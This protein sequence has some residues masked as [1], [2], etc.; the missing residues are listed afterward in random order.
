MRTTSTGT[1]VS[2][3]NTDIECLRAFAVIGVV[4]THAQ[5]DLFRPG[6]PWLERVFA[7]VEPWCGVD[8]FFAIS[9]FV[10]ARSLLPQLSAVSGNLSAQCHVVATFWIRRAWRLLPS[11][12]LWLALILLASIIANRSGVFGSVG[13]NLM[14]TLAGLFNVA[15]LRF[16]DTMFRSP[17]GASF[18][19]WSLSLE[20]QFYIALPLLAIGTRRYFPWVLAAL[21][22]MQL[23]MQRSVL[24]MA[25]RTDALSLGVLLAM[26]SSTRLYARIEPRI[27][28]RIR[29]SGGFVL[30]LL[31]S[32]M[33]AFARLNNTCSAYAM[34]A[35][36]ITA[37]ILV[38]IASYNENYLIQQGRLKRA[39]IWVGNRSYAIY[40]CHI[41]VFFLL[42]ECAFRLGIA[43]VSAWPLSVTAAGLIALAATLNFRFVEQPL[44]RHG[45]LVAE[46]FIARRTK[47][48]ES[49]SGQ[50]QQSAAR[51]NQATIGA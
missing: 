43:H 12:W 44:R 3:P 24:L 18:V 11:A 14:A 9:G 8:L 21:V 31:L 39:L 7:I 28:G 26:A 30:I 1:S 47:A 41:P 10:I 38:W 50:A 22:A 37:T 25:L 13:V 32:L 27:L 23:P 20:E 19:Y 35:V 46:R 29:G 48:V 51:E 49:A 17:Y 34:G 42:R 5:S 4:I 33:G 2:P 6:L 15:N 40:L 45:R 36:A 16:A